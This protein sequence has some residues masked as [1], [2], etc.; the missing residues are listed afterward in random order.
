MD[1]RQSDGYSKKIQ[2]REQ[3]H[4]ITCREM[5]RLTLISGLLVQAIASV[6]ELGG[7]DL[8]SDLPFNS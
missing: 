1:R 2:M 8:V 7:E 3:K 4:T 5:M 6:A